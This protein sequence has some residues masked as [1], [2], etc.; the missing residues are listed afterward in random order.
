MNNQNNL[1]TKLPRELVNIILEYDG[2]IK[3]TPSDI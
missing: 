3:Y 1:F 2:R